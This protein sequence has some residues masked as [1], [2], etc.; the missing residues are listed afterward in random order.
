MLEQETTLVCCPPAR[1][2]SNFLF[3]KGGGAAF[4]RAIVTSSHNKSYFVACLF[5]RRTDKVMAFDVRTPK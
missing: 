4:L 1:Y 2:P 5:V 3:T